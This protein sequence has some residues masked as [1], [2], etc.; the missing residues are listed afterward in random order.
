[1]RGKDHMISAKGE[2]SFIAV[3]IWVLWKK[4]WSLV[5]SISLYTLGYCDMTK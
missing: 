2:K 1:M 4:N 5:Q 3:D